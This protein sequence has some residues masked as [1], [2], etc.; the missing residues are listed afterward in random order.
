M[1][2]RL[3]ILSV[4]L[5]DVRERRLTS[6]YPA[7]GLGLQRM[8]SAIPVDCSLLRPAFVERSL[9]FGAAKGKLRMSWRVVSDCLAA[10]CLV[11]LVEALLNVLAL[12]LGCVVGLRNCVGACE[13]ALA[14]EFLLGDVDAASH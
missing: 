1:A 4:R 3:V 5:Q 2:A 6:F 14:N 8:V 7:S 10:A 11:G 12:K 9:K 13:P